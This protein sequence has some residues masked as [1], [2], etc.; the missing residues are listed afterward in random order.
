MLIR[1]CDRC[2]RDIE[3]NN[4]F[5][6]SII[7]DKDPLNVARREQYDLCDSCLNDV[8]NYLSM[9]TNSFA[10][11]QKIQKGAEPNAAETISK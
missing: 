4:C 6:F 8:V 3:Y 11:S 7:N 2:N 5:K 1:I 9:N 10:D